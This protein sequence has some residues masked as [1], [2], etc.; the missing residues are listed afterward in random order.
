M[1]SAIISAGLWSSNTCSATPP[2]TCRGSPKGCGKRPLITRREFTVSLSLAAAT[3]P[4]WA[5][6]PAKRHLIVFVFGA[7]PAAS[8]RENRFWKPFFSELRRLGYVE[9]NNLVVET[10]SSGG[11]FERFSDV[12]HQAVSRNPD[13]IVE[14]GRAHV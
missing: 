12:A 1:R 10:L 2:T 9:G 7:G 14:I 13:V 5:Q 4:A 3:R 6:A 11:H 8:W